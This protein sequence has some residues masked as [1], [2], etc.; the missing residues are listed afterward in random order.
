AR[1]R[2]AG[3]LGTVGSG[4]HFI[5]IQRVERVFDANTTTTIKLTKGTM[6]VLIHSGSRGLGH[7]VCTDFVKR[8]DAALP[9][10]GITL[11]DRQLSCAPASSE[12]GEAYLAA[13]AAAAN[14]AW[15]NR[16]AMTHLIRGAVARV[17]SDAAAERTRQV[18]DVAHNV[19]KRET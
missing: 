11:P 1:A 4:N 3:Q 19:A 14:F 2:G 15:A 16:H 17:L 7:Q 6:T 12:D 18:Y 5:E 9:R 8:M 10:H 13:M